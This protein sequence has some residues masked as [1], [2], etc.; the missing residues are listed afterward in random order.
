MQYFRLKNAVQVPKLGFGTAYIKGK[1]CVSA[2][3]SA[4][5]IGYR[6]IDTATLYDNESAVGE[7]II[8]SKIDRKDIFLVTKVWHDCLQQNNLIKSVEQSLKKLKTDYVDLLLIHWPNVRI[9]LK[10]TLSAMRYLQ[11]QHKI[12]F[13][14]V[15]N[16]SSKLLQSACAI[17]PDLVCNQVEYH[18]FLEQKQL[19]QFILKRKGMFLTAYSPLARGKVFEE[20][21]LQKI[22][23]SYGKTAGQVSLRWLIE[24]DNVVAIPKASNR[25]HAKA[26]FDIFDFQLS[27]K[28]HLTITGLNA[29]NKRI[30]NPHWMTWD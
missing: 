7:A 19:L 29:Q 2:V 28:D 6:H 10:E 26:N 15:S 24:Q 17:L 30:I 16:F 18:P 8:A 27:A 20:P 21:I 9:P 3:R 12:L 5:E 22:G 4:L 11:E 1:N 13:A 14:G 23:G 25:K